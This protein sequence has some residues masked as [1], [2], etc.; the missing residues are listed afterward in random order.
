MTDQHMQQNA[1]CYQCSK[2][3]ASKRSINQ[4]SQ[5]KEDTI[6]PSVLA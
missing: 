1:I 4:W 6:E 2:S 3:N 5:I